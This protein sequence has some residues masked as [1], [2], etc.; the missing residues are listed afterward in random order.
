MMEK[1]IIATLL[2]LF[3]NLA[4]L[5]P[6]SACPTCPYPYPPPPPPPPPSRVPCPPP[7]PKVYPP[8]PPKVKPPPPPPP[9]SPPSPSPPPPPPPKAVPP[10]PPK[11]TPCP[12]PPPPKP[13]PCPPPAAATCPIDTLKLD[14]CVDVLGGLVHIG[15]GSGASGACCP[16]LQGLVD[17]DA[18]LCLCTPIKAKLLNIGIL[19]PI[20]LGVLVNDCGKHVPSGFQCS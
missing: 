12:P 3:V 11:P 19:L 20:A 13:K 17:L 16:A 4:S 5:V 18:A 15:I 7:P 14:A 6:S 1:C 10:P 8:P 9:P 2:V